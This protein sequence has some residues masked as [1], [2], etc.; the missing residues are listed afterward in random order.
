MNSPA[1]RS[2]PTHMQPFLPTL[3]GLLAAGLLA[4]AAAP[5]DFKR[6]VA[7]ILEQRCYECHGEKKQK[8]GIRFD[9]KATVFSGGDAGKPLVVAGKSAESP[10]L[11]KV[12]ST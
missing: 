5:V 2:R 4:Q 9:R 11:Q 6:E 12:I 3:V 7:P 10:L 1:V 8:G